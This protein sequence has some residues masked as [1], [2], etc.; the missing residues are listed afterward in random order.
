MTA[1]LRLDELLVR[2]GFFDDVHD[3]QAAVMAGEVVVGEHRETSAGLR[4]G[5]DAP[6]RLKSSKKFSRGGFAS[7][8]GVKL[9]HALGVFHVDVSG[10]R[11]ADLGCSTG[12]FT[13]CLLQRGAS[14]VCAVDV[15]RAD[16]DW[17][18]RNDPR[19]SLF[20]RT[21]VRGIDVALVGGPFELVVA[22]LSFIRLASVL[23]DV[24][25]LLEPAGMFVSLVK[26][27][28]ELSAG[29]VGEGGVVREASSHVKA[30][31]ELDGALGSCGLVALSYCYSP[32][33]GAKGNI[34]FFVQAAP[35]GSGLG[36]GLS[37]SAA[38]NEIERV[39]DEAHVAL[40][41]RT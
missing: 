9:D 34:E 39:V 30:L 12:G 11:C 26:P 17:K 28:F 5:E 10:L 38:E 19:V 20:E 13:D 2:R 41:G 1:K 35:L 31:R 27:Q 16:F 23:P 22:D 15:G 7:R 4:V 32:I 25:R 29:Q 37:A 18:L 14:R 24:A 36:E 40:G 8:G 21:N 3:A 33:A 6:I